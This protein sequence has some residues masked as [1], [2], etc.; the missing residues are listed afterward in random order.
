MKSEVGHI[1]VSDVSNLMIAGR[2]LVHLIWPADN[3][4]LW[5]G[6]F[7]KLTLLVIGIYAIVH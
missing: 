4:L 2:A 3:D 1:V 5:T 6:Q 7:I